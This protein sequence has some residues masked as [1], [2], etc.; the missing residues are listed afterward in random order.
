[1]PFCPAIAYPL[2][3]IDPAGDDNP[4]RDD[5]E[6]LLRKLRPVW[7]SAA[8]D[9]N[10][11]LLDPD[12]P[13]S[14]AELIAGS[15]PGKQLVIPALLESA[16]SVKPLARL[17][18]PTVGLL[19]PETMDEVMSNEDR[20]GVIP[21]Q[22][23]RRCA[24]LGWPA[25][26]RAPPKVVLLFSKDKFSP[27]SRC[28]AE[29][30]L[31]FNGTDIEVRLCS[32][33]GSRKR[34]KLT[35]QDVRI[36][37]KALDP[38][39]LFSSIDRALIP[40]LPADLPA[41]M[42]EEVADFWQSSLR[43]HVL[44]AGARPEGAM[45]NRFL[46][47]SRMMVGTSGRDAAS[48]RVVLRATL[49][50]SSA[51]CICSAHKLKPVET[52]YPQCKFA[53][54]KVDFTLS[55]CGR[56]LVFPS[57]NMEFG[58]CPLHQGATPR[59]SSFPDICCHGTTAEVSC[60]HFTDKREFKPGLFIRNIPLDKVDVLHVQT[61]LAGAIRCTDAVGPMVAKRKREEIYE[62]C[63]DMSQ[64]MAAN[65]EAVARH[66]VC[67]PC[68]HDSG[69]LLRLD[70]RAADVLR[71]GSARQFRRR[72]TKEIV[73]ATHKEEGGWA[74]V[75]KPDSDLNTRHVWMFKPP[76]R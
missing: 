32:F 39:F 48:K 17:V 54:S 65:L 56:K 13:G 42:M 60:A 9:T 62:T 37:E 58:V 64:K 49:H 63:A 40:S 57:K 10:A 69:T 28:D 21:V 7:R 5:G 72:T 70:E 43:A 50:P 19:S 29:L 25:D 34:V 30:E 12:A 16:A 67:Q 23:D 31:T 6:P 47:F 27:E 61:L 44:V 74:P 75:S 33:E 59:V 11:H 20:S 38:S 45:S 66:R 1:M 24:V 35:V 46:S 15:R 53:S 18:A 68:A 22:G 14:L 26:M 41:S 73:L 36:V 52:Q 71:E 2:S 76:P 8:R 4:N 3:V 55:M 51:E